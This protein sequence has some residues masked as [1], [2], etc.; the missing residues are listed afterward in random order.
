MG[1][2]FV[3]E[4]GKVAVFDGGA[5]AD[6]HALGEQIMMLGGHVDAWFITHFHSDHV[7]AVVGVLREYDLTV[8]TSVMTPAQC[9]EK[10]Y[11]GLL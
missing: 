8:D 9:S 11:D 1:Y 7:G 4:Q 6:T 3:T 2:L 5:E 10:I